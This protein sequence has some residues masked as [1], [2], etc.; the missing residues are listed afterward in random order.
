MGKRR[1]LN[2]EIVV[3]TAARLANEAGTADQVSLTE[4]ARTLDVQVPSLYNHVAGLDDLRRELAL[5]GGREL[6]TRLRRAAFGLSGREALLAMAHAYRAFAHDQPGLYAL[7]LRAPDPDDAA[8]NAIA[9]ELLQMLALVLASYALHGDDALHAIRG[10]RAVLHGF[11]SLEMGGGYELPLARDES[12]Q[13]LIVTYVDGL[14][15][16]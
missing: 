14:A 9:E 11:V 7:T 13:R 1:W 6:T 4:V 15:P 2:K 12:F 5:L 10:F 3:D 16:E 8:L